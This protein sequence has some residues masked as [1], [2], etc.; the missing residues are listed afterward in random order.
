MTGWHQAS[1]ERR[2]H[3]TFK[4]IAVLLSLT[5]VG[6]SA[7]SLANSETLPKHS[8]ERLSGVVQILAK[9][10][11]GRKLLEQAMQFWNLKDVK[12]VVRFL[13][14]DSASR[15]DA[16]LIRHFDPR[17]GTEDRERK[18]TVFLR[19][20]QKLEEVVMDLAHELSHAVAKPVWD[21]YDPDLSAGDYLYSSIEGPGGE[22]D[23]VARECQ[24]ATELSGFGDFDLSRCERYLKPVAQEEQK[25]LRDL[26]RVDFYKVGR[27]Y[28]K[29]KESLG[30]QIKRFP[31]LSSQNPR[32]YSSTGQ[33]PY[34]YALLREYE[35]LTQIACENSRNRLRSFSDRQPASVG[36]RDPSRSVR[37]FLESRCGSTSVS[38]A[39][40]RRGGNPHHD[41]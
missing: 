3:F 38:G 39:S 28:S 8:R 40:S 26:I 32:L 27:W 11:S 37:L 13:R 2:T 14:W 10:A 23:A 20:N 12:E 7:Q 5:L 29:L 41:S 34:P 31:L 30:V 19:S 6:L 22:I 33:S 4:G 25:I 15:T 16:V 36:N 24:V 1:E 17:T 9:S 18:V 35:E 21:P